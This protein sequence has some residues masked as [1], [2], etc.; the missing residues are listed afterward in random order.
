MEIKF[1]NFPKE[2][3]DSDWYSPQKLSYKRPFLVRLVE[4]SIPPAFRSSREFLGAERISIPFAADL[5]LWVFNWSGIEDAED[6]IAFV[7][8]TPRRTFLVDFRAE[9]FLNVIREIYTEKIDFKKH[10]S[11]YLALYFETGAVRRKKQS[12][13][14][15][16][17][18]V[19]RPENI[20][21]ERWDDML[22]RVSGNDEPV[23]LDREREALYQVSSGYKKGF[24]PSIEYKLLMEDCVF[25][26]PETPGTVVGLEQPWCASMLHLLDIPSPERR[27]E[28]NKESQR[29]LKRLE[30]WRPSDSEAD[31]EEVLRVAL[32]NFERRC[33]ERRWIEIWPSEDD[34]VLRSEAR[35]LFAYINE[36]CLDY[37]IPDAWAQLPVTDEIGDELRVLRKTLSFYNGHSHYEIIDRRGGYPRRTEMLFAIADSEVPEGVDRLVPLNGMSATLHKLNAAYKLN[38]N[39]TTATEYL[40]F[41]CDM[42]HGDEG[43]FHIVESIDDA[44]WRCHSRDQRDVLSDTIRP[45]RIWPVSDPDKNFMVADAFLT[46]SDTFFHACFHVYPDGSVV[47]DDDTPVMG[48]MGMVPELFTTKTH[49]LLRHPRDFVLP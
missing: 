18:E 10:A 38:L 1:D 30:S 31:A 49:F 15:S 24:L 43:L 41:F 46:Y 26:Q 27:A 37:H 5:Y 28:K 22:E 19:P 36:R 39:S 2:L 29:A 23:I 44:K 33:S 16:L 42:V 32:V 21:Q 34:D 12:L 7:W 17:D 40:D 6:A 8:D 45:I 14:L 11:A 20:E 35:E 47:M 3:H 9:T 25:P 13:A 48:R 4:A